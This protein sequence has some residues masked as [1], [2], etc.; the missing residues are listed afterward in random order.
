MADTPLTDEQIRAK[1]R[2]R[3]LDLDAYA[4]TLML[5]NKHGELCP[6]GQ[7][8]VNGLADLAEELIERIEQDTDVKGIADQIQTAYNTL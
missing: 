7:R 1:M 3:L 5:I 8:A 4:G 6:D 2:D